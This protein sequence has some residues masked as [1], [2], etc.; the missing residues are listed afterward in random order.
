MKSKHERMTW[1]DHALNAT[2]AVALTA[3]FG[4]LAAEDANAQTAQSAGVGQAASD[5][6]AFASTGAITFEAAEQRRHQSVSTTPNVYAPPAMF[7][8]ANNC[9]QS[10]TVGMGFTGFGIG[11]AVASESDACNAR[12]DTA[13]A[14]KLGFMDVAQLRFFCFGLAENRM[15]YEAA[16]YMCPSSGTAKGIEGAPV[17]AAR[18]EKPRNMSTTERYRVTPNGTVRVE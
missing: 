8:G 9:G 6:G 17:L 10:N 16:G 11:G 18:L 14:A 12:E 4:I 5:A 7:G 15:A 13:I 2:L 1:R 3:I